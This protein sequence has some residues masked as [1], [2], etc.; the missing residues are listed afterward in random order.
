MEAILPLKKINDAI[1]DYVIN[2]RE[3]NNNEKRLLID[4]SIEQAMSGRNH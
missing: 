4:K 1:E 3:P 2:I